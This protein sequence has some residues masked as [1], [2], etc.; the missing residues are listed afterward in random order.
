MKIFIAT[1][2]FA[3][4]TYQAKGVLSDQERQALLQEAAKEKTL[5]NMC[6]YQQ[7]PKGQI[8]HH[9]KAL[10]KYKEAEYQDSAQLASLFNNMSHAYAALNNYGNQL[11][12]ALRA[13]DRCQIVYPENHIRVATAKNNVGRAYANLGA[14][15]D[16][17]EFHIPALEVYEAVYGEYH[18]L[19]LAMLS[20]IGHAYVMLKQFEKSL[21]YCKRSL[22]I[23]QDTPYHYKVDP[24]HIVTTLSDIGFAY[25]KLG[26]FKKSLKYSQYALD[27]HVSAHGRNNLQAAYLLNNVG[28]VYIMSGEP[29]KGLPCSQKALSIFDAYFHAE[30]YS[31]IILLLQN[32]I[33]AYGTLQN[34]DKQAQYM[35]RMLIAYK[36]VYGEGSSQAASLCIKLEELRA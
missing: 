5:G 33:D 6:M 36:K 25:G 7:N 14:Y 24:P 17:L 1:F 9:R 13:L 34:Y 30:C 4:L 2:I 12:F 21:N 26:E 35:E 20:N 23:C 15:K 19:V 8:Q 28:S 11:D 22:G 31:D 16:Q 3:F 10:G 18:P 32:I 27:S 29:E